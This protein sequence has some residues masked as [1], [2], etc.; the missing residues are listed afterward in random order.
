MVKTSKE[1]K[2]HKMFKEKTEKKKKKTEG[3]EE[4]DT[5]HPKT[6]KLLAVRVLCFVNPHR[7][8]QPYSQCRAFRHLTA[9]IPCKTPPSDKNALQRTAVSVLEKSRPFAARGYDARG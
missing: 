9:L 5:S 4:T 2:Q 1:G 6:N 7:H 3:E 8:A